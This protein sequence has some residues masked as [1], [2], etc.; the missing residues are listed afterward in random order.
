[1]TILCNILHKYFAILRNRS[2]TCYKLSI[3]KVRAAG[4]DRDIFFS[5]RHAAIKNE[6]QYFMFSFSLTFSP[7]AFD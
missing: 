2:H 7:D 1:M 3:N 5:L 6:S 4:D